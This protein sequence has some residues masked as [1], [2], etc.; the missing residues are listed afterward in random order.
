MVQWLRL[1]ASNAKGADSIPGQGNKILHAS[2]CSQKNKQTKRQTE[3][4]SKEENS[5]S[6]QA[7]PCL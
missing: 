4:K 1:H 5:S 3:D 2:W 6:S 7:E